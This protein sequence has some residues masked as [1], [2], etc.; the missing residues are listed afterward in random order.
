MKA[1]ETEYGEAVDVTPSKV[2]VVVDDYV[3]RDVP[4]SVNVTGSVPSGYYA[5]EPEISTSIISVSGA[6]G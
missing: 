6:R 2:T 4:V 3:T 1:A 5:S